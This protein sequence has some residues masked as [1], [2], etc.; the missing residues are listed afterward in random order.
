MSDQNMAPSESDNKSFYC[1]ENASPQQGERTNT[2]AAPPST[3]EVIAAFRAFAAEHGVVLPTELLTGQLTRCDTTGRNGEDDAAYML[4]VDGFPNGGIQNWQT[5]GWIKWRWQGE[6]TH[7]DRATVRRIAQ[8]NLDA[9][10]ERERL[11]DKAEAEAAAYWDSCDADDFHNMEYLQRKRLQGPHGARRA[12]HDY[13]TVVPMRDAAGVLRNVQ[14]IVHDGTKR[15][16]KDAPFI[17]LRHTIGD[18]DTAKG[19]CIGEGFAT[20]ASIMEPVPPGVAGVVAFSSD[21]LLAVTQS[22]RVAYPNTEIM[23]LADD[24]RHLEGNPGLT[25]AR[26]A[27]E[28]VNG[29]LTVP[30]DLPEGAS[31]FDDVRRLYGLEVVKA[32]V[33]KATRALAT[34]PQITEVLPTQTE[35]WAAIETLNKQSDP[36]AI[37]PVIRMIADA[38]LGPEWH[39]P[40]LA[41]IKDLTAHQTLPALR[42]LLRIAIGPTTK[43]TPAITRPNSP[44]WISHPDIALGENLEPKGIMS[45]VTVALSEAPE[46]KGAIWFD[47]FSRKIRVRK[48][49]PWEPGDGTPCD[50]REWTKEDLLATVEWVQRAGIHALKHIVQDA[51]ERVAF[52]NKFH[53]VR[54]FFDGLKWDGK[55]RLD[56]WTTYYLGVEDGPYPRAVGAC[57]LI[58]A[59]ARSYEPGCKMDTVLILEGPQGL[60]KSTTYE[61]LATRKDWYTDQISALHSKDAAIDTVGKLII[62]LAELDSVKRAE[63]GQVKAFASRAVDHYRPP[64]EANSIDVP[65]Q[66]VFGGTVNEDEYLKDATGGRR[67]WPLRCTSIDLDALKHDVHQLWAEAVHRHKVGEKWHLVDEELISAAEREQANR[68]E[69]DVWEPVIREWLARTTEASVTTADVFQGA[70]D[71]KDKIKWG[72]AE[73]M[74]VAA[75][76]RHLGWKRQQLWIGTRPEW[77][78]VKPEN[79]EER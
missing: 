23:L 29:W 24:D 51:V 56:T 3:G 45:N 20:V 4:H 35:V 77:R 33:S 10:R 72:K 6:R 69:S 42:E 25:K 50:A 37:R 14:R 8:A 7:V 44:A 38:R 30:T 63:V 43:M 75:C 21:N 61:T 67:F 65:R 64:Y 73:Q 74:R 40:T 31:D 22:I 26:E 28:A 16:W 15:F 58:G 13:R 68:F 32:Q 48:R 79:A 54:D 53:P 59:V 17:G 47:E 60:G 5:G 2:R 76:L 27:A 78:Y 19:I 49:L 41:R 57:Y 66:F 55:P 9:K 36:N 18:L 12:S 34:Q 52:K 1:I 39:G 11:R 46:L 70:L 71:V 62:E